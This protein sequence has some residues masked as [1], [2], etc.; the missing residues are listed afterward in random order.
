MNLLYVIMILYIN[1]HHTQRT[2]KKRTKQIR[3]AELIRDVKDHPYRD[4]L[5]KLMEEQ[6]IDDV[7]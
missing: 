5:I 1:Y 6:L 3:L 2:V 4:E 7:N